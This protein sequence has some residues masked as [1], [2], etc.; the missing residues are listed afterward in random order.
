MDLLERNHPWVG[1]K[2]MQRLIKS[3]RYFGGLICT[4]GGV[5]LGNGYGAS[6][7]RFGPFNLAWD[8]FVRGGALVLLGFLLLRLSK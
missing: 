1:W 7:W 2:V 6:Y 4:I 5:Y 3:A 8:T